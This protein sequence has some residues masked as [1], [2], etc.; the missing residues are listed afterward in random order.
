MYSRQIN[1]LI[2]DDSPVARDLLAYIIQSDPQLKVM[3]FAENG[4]D[5]LNFL[6]NQT[7]DVIIMDIVMPKMNGFELTRRI[8]QTHPIPIIVVSGIYNKDEVNK[9]FKAIE[10]GALAILEK[11]KGI[12][13]TQYL[14]TARFVIETIK[15]MSEVKMAAYKSAPEPAAKTE[16]EE[17]TAAPAKKGKAKI[18]AVAIGASIGGP[19][20]LAAIL[21]KLPA[22]LPVPIFIV[23]HISGGFVQGL[24]SW[25]NE[26]T[27]LNVKLAKNEEEALPGYVYIAPDKTQMRIQPGNKIQ[28]V[29]DLN[30]AAPA[31]S[32]AALFN[33]MSNVYGPNCLAI[34]LT[35]V[36]RDGAEDLLLIKQKGGITIAQNEESSV[37]FDMPKQAIQLGAATRVEPLQFIPTI[38]STLINP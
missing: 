38:I 16:T 34:I 5:A 21:S 1:V 19:Q 24:V 3:G 25:L 9:S 11:P 37:M 22:T 13:S 10:A 6:K 12:G 35:G 2:V 7:P 27:S 17:P 26:S 18:E 14:D 8:M 4:E 30:E 20:A 28:L 23:Q 32:I 15:A 36:G 31:P 29:E 33:S